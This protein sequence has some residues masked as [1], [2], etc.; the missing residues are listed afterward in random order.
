MALGLE[1]VEQDHFFL[2]EIPGKLQ[3]I[4]RPGQVGDPDPAMAH[5]TGHGQHHVH[6][7]PAFGFQ[8]KDQD[9]VEALELIG[10]IVGASQRLPAPLAHLAEQQAGVGAADVAGKEDHGQ[11]PPMAAASTYHSSPVSGCTC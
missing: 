3:G 7:S 5:G 6:R 2:L 11:A 4:Q 1:I 10:G 8:E 9:V